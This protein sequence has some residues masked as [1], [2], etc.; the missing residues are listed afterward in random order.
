MEYGVL[1]CIRQLPRQ[2][3][4]ESAVQTAAR[5]AAGMGK[6]QGGAQSG[7]GR[8]PAQYERDASGTEARSAACHRL[9]PVTGGGAVPDAPWLLDFGK[10]PNDALEKFIDRQEAAFAELVTLGG[11]EGDQRASNKDYK[12]GHVLFQF[13]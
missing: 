12:L 10:M 1:R 3:A 4:E 11:I 5:P 2:E 13:S 9:R 7:N 6:S 8:A